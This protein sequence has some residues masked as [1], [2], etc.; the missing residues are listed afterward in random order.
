LRPYA[1]LAPA[2]GERVAMIMRVVRG[3][4]DK[5]LDFFRGM[6]NAIERLP[7]IHAGARK[8]GALEHWRYGTLLR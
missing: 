5:F 7:C 2:P 4:G 1:Q 3:G 6:L 8:L